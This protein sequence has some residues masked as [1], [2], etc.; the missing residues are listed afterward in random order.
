MDLKQLSLDILSIYK[1]G[2]SQI[3]ESVAVDADILLI[4]DSMERL[5]RIEGLIS[6]VS[7]V[8]SKDA[9]KLQR[10]IFT[11]ISHW[12]ASFAYKHY[13][14]SA[15]A[16]LDDAISVA[17]TW[18]SAKRRQDTEKVNKQSKEDFFS[19]DSI[20]SEIK[21][22]ATL[23]NDIKRINNLL[24]LITESRKRDI[25]RDIIEN[26]R[27]ELDENKHQIEK[28]NLQSQE[29]VQLVQSGQMAARKALEKVKVFMSEINQL[30]HQGFLIERRISS[31]QSKRSSRFFVLDN[32]ENACNVV[33]G[34][35]DPP[36]F[37]SR[38]LAEFN[39][40]AIINFLNDDEA[41]GNINL[42]INLSQVEKLIE[43]LCFI[44]EPY[45]SILEQRLEE[46]D[47][48]DSTDYSHLSDEEFIA[49]LK[50]IAPEAPLPD[51]SELEN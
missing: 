25:F 9:A 23:Y 20:G 8:D 18:A 40:D 4:D 38:M 39:F 26:S 30:R 37:L 16:H 50:E 34:Y 27:Q 32:I 42:M 29:L 15:V 51:F 21:N 12:E 5:H 49:M 24:F 2:L 13:T 7:D 44:C 17:K 19:A 14:E 10:S 41:T 47:A 28:L 1:D 22:L 33:L 36:S 3:R 48:M 46:Y 11:H 35:Q 45:H 6:D 43:Q 31:A